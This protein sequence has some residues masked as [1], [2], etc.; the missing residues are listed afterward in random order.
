MNKQNSETG[1]IPDWDVSNR[2]LDYYQEMEEKQKN[3][4]DNIRKNLAQITEL[5][6]NIEKELEILGL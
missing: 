2:I 6:A 1:I 3:A 5:I 4:P